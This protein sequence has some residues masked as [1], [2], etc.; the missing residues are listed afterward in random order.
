MTN[1]ETTT[2]VK[3]PSIFDLPEWTGN[4]PDESLKVFE[5]PIVGVRFQAVGKVYHYNAQNIDNLKVGAWVIVDTARG[6]QMGQVATLKPPRNHGGP[7]KR[8]E[9]LA[10]G[11]DMAMRHYYENKQLEAMIACR[12]ESAALKLPI[13]I[14]KAEYS[15]DGQTI[16]FLYS[17]DEDERVE[18][19]ALRERMSHLYQARLEFRQISPREVAKILGGMGACGIEERCCSKFLTEFSPISI[20]HAKEQNLSLN[21]HDIT[22]MCGRLRCCLV[23]EY[24]QYV[25]AR[26]HL[27]KLKAVI[28]TP[29]GEGKVTEILHFK[30]S[31]KVKI[32]QGED[33]REL[34]FH[35]EQI[36]PLEELKRLQDKAMSGTCDKHEG[37]GCDCGKAEKN[38]ENRTQNL[39]TRSQKPEG[40]LTE[41][42]LSNV[43]TLKPAK[44]I[45]ADKAARIKARQE[46]IRKKQEERW[47]KRE[48]IRR[49]L[50]E[51]RTQPNPENKPEP[52]GADRNNRQTD[53]RDRDRNRRDNPQQR[54]DRPQQPQ[55]RDEQGQQNQQ[56]PPRK[57]LMRKKPDNK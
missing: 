39:E 29:A 45:D 19:G 47:Q 55:R 30:D 41:S 46:K 17:S 33:A 7:Y 52:S 38:Q 32:G 56:R 51:K 21:P 5:P 44:P 6:R 34:I 16:T 14:V 15:F 31:V 36:T 50:K 49:Q 35:R 10:N 25:E 20:K 37:G 13:K 28:G 11:R 4:Y 27:P 8:I 24:E 57:P 43:S 48:N 53:R 1:M 3:E 23:Y 22:G 42:T 54:Q 40:E 18:A 12:A 9:R 2:A 26:R